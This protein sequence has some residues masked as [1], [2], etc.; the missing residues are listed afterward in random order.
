MWLPRGDTCTFISTRFEWA[1]Q[2]Y[3]RSG[4]RKSILIS[5]NYQTENTRGATCLNKSAYLNH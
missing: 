3:S 1:S 5:G 2:Q 4:R